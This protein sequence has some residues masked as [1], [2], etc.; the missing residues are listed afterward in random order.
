MKKFEENERKID[1]PREHQSKIAAFLGA[2]AGE[3]FFNGG[4]DTPKPKSP[5][6]CQKCDRL[7]NRASKHAWK[8]PVCGKIYNDKESAKL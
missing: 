7:M 5:T 3:G 1:I 2:L 6:Y 8:C 4:S